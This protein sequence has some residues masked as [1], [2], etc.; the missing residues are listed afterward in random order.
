M[1][2]PTV[3]TLPCWECDDDGWAET[4]TVSSAEFEVKSSWA[5]NG[6]GVTTYKKVEKTCPKC[7]DVNVFTMHEDDKLGLLIS[8]DDC[9]D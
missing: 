3:E 9:E 1:A 2:E 5:R 8:H 6:Y 4:F 7:G